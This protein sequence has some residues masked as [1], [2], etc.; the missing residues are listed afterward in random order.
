MSSN[1][2]LSIEPSRGASQVSATP[3]QAATV[4]EIFAGPAGNWHVHKEGC[5]RSR[6]SVTRSGDRLSAR[7]YRM[8]SLIDWSSGSERAQRDRAHRRHHA[9]RPPLQ[10]CLIAGRPR[11][12]PA[13]RGMARTSI[14]RGP[15]I[16]CCKQSSAAS[17]APG[18]TARATA[19][20]AASPR[21]AEPR[22][23][24]PAPPPPARRA[25]AGPVRRVPLGAQANAEGDEE[26]LGKARTLHD[27]AIR[28]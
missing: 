2:A 21:P 11:S 25:N 5:D 28:A 22:S 4:F 14:M 1:A 13:S 10:F 18:S 6:V 9:D 26:Q 15:P 8:R 12:S 3:K 27:S 24:A 19:R 17:G 23:G 7:A 20:P 16:Q